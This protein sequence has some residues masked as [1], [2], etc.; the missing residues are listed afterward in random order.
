VPSGSDRI[1]TSTLPILPIQKAF[2]RDH[3]A[4]RSAARPRIQAK[5]D[6]VGQP[7]CWGFVGVVMT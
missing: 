1:R 7:A 6:P 2:L 3:H 4:E 5:P